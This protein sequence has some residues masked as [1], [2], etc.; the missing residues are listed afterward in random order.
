MRPPLRTILRN[1]STWARPHVVIVPVRPFHQSTRNSIA[2]SEMAE[3]NTTERLAHLRDLMK[4]HQLD[5]YSMFQQDKT[6]TIST[7]TWPVVPSE[8]SHQS[9]YIAPCDARRGS[10]NMSASQIPR[11]LTRISIHMWFHWLCRHRGNYP[12]ESC[13]G[14]GRSLFQPSHKTAGCELVPS[15]AR[16]DRCPNLARMVFTQ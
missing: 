14:H 13:L 5:V 1:T 6:A 15:Q 4:K 10:R 2:H 16:S 11:Q 8:D 3:V 9:E 12:R 7:D